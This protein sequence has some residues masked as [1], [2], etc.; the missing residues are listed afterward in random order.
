MECVGVAELQQQVETLL[1]TLVKA[2]AVELTKLFESTYLAAA[3]AADPG[4]GDRGGS[5]K[6]FCSLNPAEDK[7]SIGVQV[8]VFDC[9]STEMHG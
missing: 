4:L 8:E 5:V 7:Q 3:A 2:A 6:A 1:G 9:L